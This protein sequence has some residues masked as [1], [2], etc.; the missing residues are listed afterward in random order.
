MRKYVKE[1]CGRGLMWGAWGGPVI[2]AI[3]WLC[4]K[5]A[6]VVTV[7]TVDEAVLGIFSTAVM[8]FLAAGVS[9]V[10][11]IESMPITFAGLIN[12]VV[13]YLVYLGVYLLNGWL[14]LNKVWI[15]TLIFVCGFVVIW[16][17]IYIPIRIKVDKMNQKLNR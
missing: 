7:L 5:K 14:A 4:L 3:V 17:A 8:G 10:Y 1:F 16:L 12:C 11:K 13:L 9:V 2:L 15:F 6:G